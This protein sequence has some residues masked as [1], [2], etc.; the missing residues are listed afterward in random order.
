MTSIRLRDPEQ[1]ISAVLAA[2]RGAVQGPEVSLREL[3]GALG[4]QGLLVFCALLAAPFLLPVTVPMMSTVLGVPMLL[5]AFAVMVSRVPWLPERLLARR[6]P[7]DTVRTVLGRVTGWALRFEHLVRPRWLALSGSARINVM[8]GGLLGAAVLTL[9]APL[10]LVPFVNTLPAI[11]IVLLCFGMAER[12]GVVIALGWL[13]TLVSAAYVGG[14][15]LLVLY[16]GMHSGQAF[17]ALRRF[18]GY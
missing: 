3:L 11:A 10:P 16:A 13:V 8:N 15:L 14:L 2:A 17:E 1:R 4:E 7:G 9:M 5:I 12:D 6:L 18:L